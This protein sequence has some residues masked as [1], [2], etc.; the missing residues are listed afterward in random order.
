MLVLGWS[1]QNEE[2]MWRL[3]SQSSSDLVAQKLT[4]P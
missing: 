1:K 3:L 4:E 2:T